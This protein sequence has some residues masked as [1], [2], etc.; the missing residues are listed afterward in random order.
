MVAPIIAAA[1]LSKNEDRTKIIASSA[2]AP[3]HPFGNIVE[4]ASVTLLFSK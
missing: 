1:M 2:N 4:T 3:C